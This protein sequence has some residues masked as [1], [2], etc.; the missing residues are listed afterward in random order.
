[1]ILFQVDKVSFNQKINTMGVHETMVGQADISCK[2]QYFNAPVGQWEPAI[3]RLKLTVKLEGNGK[4]QKQVISAV[5]PL[6]INV[7]VGLAGVLANF[8]K[9]W[10]VSTQKALK[11]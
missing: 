3:E 5:T 4:A 2:M 6:N 11:F 10:T 9:L 1:M 7:S 8:S